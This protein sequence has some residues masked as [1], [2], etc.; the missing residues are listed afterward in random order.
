MSKIDLTMSG[1]IKE[2]V[3]GGVIAPGINENIRCKNVEYGKTEKSEFLDIHH[4]QEETGRTLRHREFIPGDTSPSWTT[5]AEEWDRFRRRMSQLMYAVGIPADKMS[6]EAESKADF[7]QKV[8]ARVNKF[9]EL[10][11]DEKYRLKVLLDKNNLQ[12]SEVP[13][14]GLVMENQNITPS[15]L[16]ISKK[17]EARLVRISEYMT[18]SE[19]DFVKDSDVETKKDTYEDDMPF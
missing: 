15:K 7:A 2:T 14:R 12:Y 10:E 18:T 3:S 4:T 1:D 8:A 19:E 5:P 13:D 6:F 11:K 17:E 9:I 16:Y